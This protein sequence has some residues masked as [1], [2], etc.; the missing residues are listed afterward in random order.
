MHDVSSAADFNTAWRGVTKAQHTRL[1]RTEPK[2]L[3]LNCEEQ[4]ASGQVV[5]F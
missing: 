4:P 1:A 5:R 3:V 2:N